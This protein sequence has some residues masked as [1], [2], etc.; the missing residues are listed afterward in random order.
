M[1]LQSLVLA[2]T[3]GSALLI[4]RFADDRH[5]ATG[6]D[7]SSYGKS[8]VNLDDVVTAVVCPVGKKGEQS[9]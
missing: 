7:S 3:F 5:I 1:S 9:A 6:Y 2:S 4:A 8:P